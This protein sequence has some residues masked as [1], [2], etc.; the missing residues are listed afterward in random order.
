MDTVCSSTLEWPKDYQAW[1]LCDA[2][3]DFREKG[4]PCPFCDPEDFIEYEWGLSDE[5]EVLWV[6]DGSP[7]GNV[8][9]H[10]H[11]GQALW[12]SATHPDRGE[13]RVLIRRLEF[14]D[15]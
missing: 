5:Y 12:W 3:D 15:D 13:E 14:E 4:V 10:F 7:A 6:S 8:E 9:I 2:D 1:G 11:D